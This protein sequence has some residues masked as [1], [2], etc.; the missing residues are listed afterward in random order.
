MGIRASLVAASTRRR[1]DRSTRSSV[2]PGGG[3]MPS[4]MVGVV[5]WAEAT[6][7]LPSTTPPVN[8]APT[9]PKNLRLVEPLMETLLEEGFPV[10]GDLDAAGFSLIIFNLAD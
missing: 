3:V 8:A 2:T 5:Y 9:W 6:A 1:K 10:S 7:A 4:P